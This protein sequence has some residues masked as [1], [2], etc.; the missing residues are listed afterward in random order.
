LKSGGSKVLEFNQINTKTEIFEV[1][2][3]YNDKGKMF[4]ELIEEA[5]TQSISKKVIQS[6]KL[7]GLRCL[8]P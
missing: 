3:V 1:I 4:Q 5:F 2:S 7:G 6:G 8:A